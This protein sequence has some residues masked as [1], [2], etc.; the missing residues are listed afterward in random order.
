M[1]RW[2]AEVLRTGGHVFIHSWAKKKSRVGTRL[3]WTLRIEELV[4]EGDQIVG[5]ERETA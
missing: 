5:V 2:T 4:L 3:F 1:K